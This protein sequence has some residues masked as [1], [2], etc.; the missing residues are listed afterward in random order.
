MIRRYNYTSRKKI[1][2]ERIQICFKKDSLG[3]YFDA[4]LNLT[5]IDLPENS[6]VYVESYFKTNYMRFEYGKVGKV[7]KPNNTYLSNFVGMDTVFFRVKVVD[8]DTATGRILALVS[9]IKLQDEEPQ[10]RN[11]LSLLHVVFQDLGQ[12]LYNL[13]FDTDSFPILIVNSNL[14][15]PR[16][17]IRSDTLITTIYPAVV[18]E[19]A[20]EIAMDDEDYNLDDDCWQG[21]WLRYFNSIL[22]LNSP[23]PNH[24]DSSDLKRD[25]I[26]E[27]VKTFC[28]RNKIRNRFNKLNIN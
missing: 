28:Y 11:K 4:D 23:K 12:E 21:Y 5:G 26:E 16:V 20:Y 15:N 10:E 19:I 3:R 25:W 24:D 13:G 2:R 22:K 8:E 9:G 6:K 1:K 27:V 7:E 14:K 17:L 18:K